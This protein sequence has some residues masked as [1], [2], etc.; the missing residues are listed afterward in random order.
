[1]S[2]IVDGIKSKQGRIAFSIILG[3]GLAALFEKKCKDNECMVINVDKSFNSS[4]IERQK[5][6]SEET[7]YKYEKVIIA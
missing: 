2:A 6:G 3:V 7:C 5:K 1:M 4:E